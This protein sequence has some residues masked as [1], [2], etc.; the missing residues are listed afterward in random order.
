MNIPHGSKAMNDKL[1][2]CLPYFQPKTLSLAEIA[3]RTQLPKSTVHW[4]WKKFQ[5]NVPFDEIRP[6]GRPPKM[7]TND[8]RALGPLM[9]SKPF[10]TLSSVA[11]ALARARGISVSESP[12]RRSLKALDYDFGAPQTCLS[13]T[14][15]HKAARLAFAAR[16]A[17]TDW[18]RVVFSDESTFQLA[19]NNVGVWSKKG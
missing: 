7:A 1:A 12:V 14:E 9:R 5:R 3:T 15:A 2:L 10:Q 18:K 4:Y 13:L 16:H 8:R 17:A 19:P 6:K 11:N